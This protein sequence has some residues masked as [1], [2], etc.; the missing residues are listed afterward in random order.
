MLILHGH[1]TV[2]AEIISQ[3]T[4]NLHTQASLLAHKLCFECYLL[5]T[6]LDD[7][8]LH[9]HQAL[10]RHAVA[11]PWIC[12]S[13]YA[14]HCCHTSRLLF[15][16]EMVAPIIVRL[17]WYMHV[18]PACSPSGVIAHV[19]VSCPLFRY[20]ANAACILQAQQAAGVQCPLHDLRFVGR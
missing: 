6:L 10:T 12:I 18:N 4:D 19:N 8:L 13:A 2:A 15:H 14:I 5:Q 3:G 16:G 1:Q 11:L 9:A 20:F 17:V 7:G